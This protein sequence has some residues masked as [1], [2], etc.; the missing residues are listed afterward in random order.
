MSL[1]EEN[2]VGISGFYRDNGKD[3][4]YYSSII[5]CCTEVQGNVACDSVLAK[6]DD[7][8]ANIA[9]KCAL[10]DQLGK[11]FPRKRLNAWQLLVR[12]MLPSIV[13]GRDTA[14]TQ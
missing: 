2:D 3:N 5:G 1:C 8:T 7:C 12:K 6:R 11:T 10:A 9:V 14:P 4:G 13:Y